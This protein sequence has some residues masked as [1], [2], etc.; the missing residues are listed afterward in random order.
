MSLLFQVLV[1]KYELSNEMFQNL[2]KCTC[3]LS[4]CWCFIGCLCQVILPIKGRATI[5]RGSIFLFL[6]SLVCVVCFNIKP[7]TI[8]I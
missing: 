1:V 3:R 6:V 8:Q 7:K 4:V 2:V 5:N